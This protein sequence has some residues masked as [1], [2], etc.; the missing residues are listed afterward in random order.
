MTTEFDG[1]VIATARYSPA[2]DGGGRVVVSGLPR[3]LFSR[4]YAITAMVLAERLAAASATMIRSSR[5]TTFQIDQHA[6][7]LSS[8]GHPVAS[9]VRWEVASAMVAISAYLA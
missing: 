9:A 3:R 5:S 2:A 7:T 6:G 4:D 8:S 1:R